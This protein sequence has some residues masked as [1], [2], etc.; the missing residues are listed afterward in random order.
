M[1]EFVGERAG[2]ELLEFRI[3]GTG[4]LDDVPDFLVNT[5]I[6]EA[7]IFPFGNILGSDGMAVEIGDNESLDLGQGVEPIDES[8]GR[9]AGV[10]AEV[11]FFQN[12]RREA[13][14]FSVAVHENNQ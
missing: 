11:Q 14:D 10:E 3:V 9:F 5:P 4:G 1:R 8:D 12:L 13:G 6:A 2:E 7:A